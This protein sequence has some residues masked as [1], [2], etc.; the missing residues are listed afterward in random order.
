LLNVRCDES[1]GAGIVGRVKCGKYGG[2]VALGGAWHLM[3]VNQMWCRV[4]H[5][6]QRTQIRIIDEI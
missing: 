4:Q 5:D 6:Q 3:G 2:F 1:H